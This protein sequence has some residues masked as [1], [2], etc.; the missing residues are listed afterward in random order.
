MGMTRAGSGLLPDV[1]FELLDSPGM[2][3]YPFLAQDHLPPHREELGSHHS[4]QERLFVDPGHSLGCLLHAV[5]L[6]GLELLHP[7]PQRD[8]PG[9]QIGRCLA[10]FFHLLLEIAEQCVLYGG[11]WRM[12]RLGLQ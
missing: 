1:F 7:F 8:L 6:R 3:G 4:K 12:L 10:G 9:L 5:A 2:L 11:W